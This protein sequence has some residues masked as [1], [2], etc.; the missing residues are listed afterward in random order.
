MSYVSYAAYVRRPT[1]HHHYVVLEIALNG[2]VEFR[3]FNTRTEVLE[4]RGWV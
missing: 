4:L 2:L 1:S 3:L